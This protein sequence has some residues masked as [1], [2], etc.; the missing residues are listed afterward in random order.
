MKKEKITF[1]VLDGCPLMCEAY[2]SIINNTNK[3]NTYDLNINLIHDPKIANNF[4]NE[5]IKN[6]TP[7][8]IVILELNFSKKND[9]NQI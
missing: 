4:I 1:L 9:E 2:K 3:G 7:L 5:V 6:K 8:D